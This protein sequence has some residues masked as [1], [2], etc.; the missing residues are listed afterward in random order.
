MAGRLARQLLPT[1]LLFGLHPFPSKDL[2][3][4]LL[5]GTG[6]TATLPDAMLSSYLIL[7]W[8]HP[9]PLWQVWV[10]MYPAHAITRRKK[11]QLPLDRRRY[12]KVRFIMTAITIVFF[13]YPSVTNALLGIFRCPLV[14]QRC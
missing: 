9:A 8:R 12:I 7:I 10:L 2:S 6:R 4:A 3:L 11:G 5:H 13:T 14:R 1:P